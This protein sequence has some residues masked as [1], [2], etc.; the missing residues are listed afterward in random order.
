MHPE[1]SA[2]TP[3]PASCQTHPRCASVASHRSSN[4]SV[5][6]ARTHTRGGKVTQRVHDCDSVRSVTSRPCTLTLMGRNKIRWVSVLVRYTPMRALTDGSEN[7]TTLLIFSAI[8]ATFAAAATQPCQEP[9]PRHHAR[10]PITTTTTHEPLPTLAR[11]AGHS[12]RPRS[13]KWCP[14]PAESARQGVCEPYAAPPVDV[15]WQ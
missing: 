13:R 5:S 10:S 12:F 6:D 15:P 3:Y 9:R 14:A 7:W 4:A 8:S 1:G 2:L 11:A